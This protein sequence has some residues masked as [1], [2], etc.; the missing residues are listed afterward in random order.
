MAQ[1]S[2]SA[3]CECWLRGRASFIIYCLRREGC[4]R[5][6]MITSEYMNAFAASHW[7][8]VLKRIH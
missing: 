8:L 6:Q 1:L 5:G 4:T 3:F 2:I 7:L